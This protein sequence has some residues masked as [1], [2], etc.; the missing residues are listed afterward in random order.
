M[1]PFQVTNSGPG[2]C[3]LSIYA[4]CGIATRHEPLDRQSLQRIGDNGRLVKRTMLGGFAAAQVKNI[5]LVPM[6]S[7]FQRLLLG[8]H[9]EIIMHA[10]G[11]SV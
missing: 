4:L 7:C 1:W 9:D 6:I 5:T 8:S 3:V 11:S 10:L 2:T